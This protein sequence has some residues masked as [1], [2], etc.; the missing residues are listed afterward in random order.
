MLLELGRT[1]S[2]F[3]SLLSLFPVLVSAFFEP[4]SRWQDRVAAIVLN[5]ALAACIC[6]SS[7]LLFSWPSRTNP[8]AGQPLLSTLPVRMFFWAMAGMA[9]LF[10]LSWYLEAYYLP[11]IRHDCCRRP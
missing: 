8:D 9:V 11:L 5:I 10:A 3:L 1:F 6:F 2:F 7:G 4:G